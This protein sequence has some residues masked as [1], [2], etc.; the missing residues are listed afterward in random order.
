MHDREVEVDFFTIRPKNLTSLEGLHNWSII[1]DDRDIRGLKVVDINGNEMGKV[2]DILVSTDIG[3]AV[4]A[5][6]DY[7]G[8]LGIGAKQALVPIDMLRFSLDSDLV[9]FQGTVDHLKNSPEYTVDMSDYDSLYDY[10]KGHMGESK[11]EG[12]SKIRIVS[13]ETVTSRGVTE[14]E[15][16]E[17][18]DVESRIER[19]TG[20]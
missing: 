7:G 5:L 4:F 11:H 18:E 13:S 20:M 9:A 2:D 8:F 6:I 15:L 12:T 17:E 3:M 10:W 16:E 19:G 1:T 14:S